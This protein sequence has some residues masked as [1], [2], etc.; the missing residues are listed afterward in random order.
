MKKTKI[1]ILGMIL[2]S[3]SCLS[4][5]GQNKEVSLGFLQTSDG[6]DASSF[7][8]NLLNENQDLFK[9]G[10]LKQR[11]EAGEKSMTKYAPEFLIFSGSDDAFN[12]YVVKLSGYHM[13]FAKTTMIAGAETPDL[14]K[15]FHVFPYALG[16]EMDK[17]F[18][19]ANVV[20]EMGYSPSMNYINNSWKMLNYCKMGAFL[21]TGYKFGES[22]TQLINTDRGDIDQSKEETGDAL[23]R[24]KGDLQIDTK[25][26]LKI[27]DSDIGIGLIGNTNVWYD[28]INSEVYYRIEGKIRFY[29]TKE[30]SFDLKYEKG[31][32]APNFNQGDQFGANLNITF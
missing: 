18:S 30:Y 15:G 21:Q 13:T 5:Y 17:S 2:L 11:F 29:I 7:L 27:K 1:T 23:F 6:N 24:I 4:S 22:D 12:G 32:G 14:R 19:F 3:V 28:V 10:Q 26:F 8:F 16:L 20:L 9:T 25:D 31:S